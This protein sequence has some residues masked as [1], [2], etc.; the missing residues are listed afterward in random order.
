MEVE[1]ESLLLCSIF[2]PHMKFDRNCYL[3]PDIRI[4]N[5]NPVVFSAVYTCM[6]VQVYV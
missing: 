5:G 6:C 4:M 3:Q 1:S 2:D